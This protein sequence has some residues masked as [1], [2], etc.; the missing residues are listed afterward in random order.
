MSV[1]AR[2]SLLYSRKA[3]HGPPICLNAAQRE[4]QSCGAGLIIKTVST[5]LFLA[6][7]DLQRLQCEV[8]H[9]NP[10]ISHCHYRTRDYRHI[11]SC[12]E[13]ER[14]LAFENAGTTPAV[15][16]ESQSARQDLTSQ[17]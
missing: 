6:L 11:A 7:E 14:V 15:R 4:F 17:A 12:A 5:K 10:V 3:D 8:H 9:Y 16:D 13:R 1:A 2:L